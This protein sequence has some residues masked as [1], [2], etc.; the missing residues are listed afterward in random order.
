[1]ARTGLLMQGWKQYDTWLFS[2]N[3]REYEN[4]KIERMKQR[5]KGRELFRRNEG[6]RSSEFWGLGFYSWGFKPV[7]VHANQWATRSLCVLTMK[8]NEEK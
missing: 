6:S 5:E 3:S 8:C 1:M 7:W 4:V 2:E